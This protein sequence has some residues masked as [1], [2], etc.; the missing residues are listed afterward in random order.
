MPRSRSAP[1]RALPEKPS[2]DQLRKQAKELLKS[3]RA[4]QPDAVAEAERFEAKPDPTS[5]TLSDAQRVLARAYG[6]ASWTKLKQHV[7]GVNIK[8]FCDAVEKGDI[9][10]VRQLAKTRPKLVKLS[11]DGEHDERIAL[12]VAVLNGNAEM[13]RTL[14]ELGSDARRGIWPHR[15][16]T[17][18]HAIATDRGCDEIVAIIEREEARRRKA[19]SAPGAT[20]SSTTNEILKAI[21]EDRCEEAVKQLEADPSLVAACNVRGATPLHVAARKHNPGM[22]AWLLDRGAVADAKD[23]EGKTPLDYASIVAGWSS[24]GRAFSLVDN[25]RLDP[26][27]FDETARLLLARGAA[28]TSRTA[29][30][31]GD[32]QAVRRMHR[33]GRLRNEIDT[34]RGG[35]LSIAVR[36]NRPEMV[37]LLLDLGFDPD[38]TVAGED[39]NRMSWGM[40]LWFTAMCGRHEIAELLLARGADVNAI[41]YASGDALSIAHDTQDDEMKALLRRRGARVTVEQVAGEKDHATARAILNGKIPAQSLNVEKPTLTDFAEQ[42]LWAAG[43]GDAEIVRMCLPYMTRKRDDPWWNYVLMHATLPESFKLIL[44]YGVDPDVASGYTILQ[45]LATD[46]APAETRLARATILLD[47]GASLRRRDPVL[48]STALGWACRWGREDLVRLYLSRGADPRESDAEPWATPLAW[49]TK[50]GHTTIAELLRALGA[51]T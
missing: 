38:E 20:V 2:L 37:S 43:G 42:M 51:T 30:A 44:E 32:Q 40:P 48:M 35:L 3:Y 33:E 19:M 9:A 8:A 27:R 34:I 10:T 36:V 6:F 14:M 50:G 45:H 47:A 15:T 12:H 1:T 25:S 24:H 11:P 26:S 13:T 22:T 31:M 4:G 7:D 17:T 23:E 16:A 5:F 39:G 21:L 18:A 29:V 49:A 46:W 41:V 28:L